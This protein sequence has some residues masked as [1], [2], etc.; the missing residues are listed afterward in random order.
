ME[1]FVYVCGY[2][3]FNFTHYNFTIYFIKYNLIFLLNF[4]YKNNLC[5]KLFPL[6]ITFKAAPLFFHKIFHI[7]ATLSIILKIYI[8]FKITSVFSPYQTIYFS[9]INIFYLFIDWLS[10]YTNTKKVIIFT[11]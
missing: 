1:N 8:F 6:W 9:P 11:L 4:F 7:F 10:S 5:R 2:Y 3:D